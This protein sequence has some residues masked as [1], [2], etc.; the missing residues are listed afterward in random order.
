MGPGW[1]DPVRTQEAQVAPW[2]R[3][4]RWVPGFLEAPGGPGSHGF[5]EQSFILFPSKTC[6][7]EVFVKF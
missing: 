4:A 6:T 3:G 2:A 1:P 5:I 7:P